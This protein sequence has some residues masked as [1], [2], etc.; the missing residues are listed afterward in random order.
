[1]RLLLC[2]LRQYNGFNNGDFSAAAKVLKKWGWNS[3]SSIQKALKELIQKRWI[4]ISRQGGLGI[5]CSL[6]AITWLAI[7]DCNGK[8]DLSPTKKAS[9]D[10][11]D[12]EL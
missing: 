11:K 5:G 2:L 3:E 9:D 10:W 12:Y 1:M 4:V 6:Y 7:D 8:I